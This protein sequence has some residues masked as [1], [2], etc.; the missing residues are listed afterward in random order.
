MRGDINLAFLKAP[1]PDTATQSGTFL[2]EPFSVNI[3][4]DITIKSVT[5]PSSSVGLLSG[6]ASDEEGVKQIVPT[7]ILYAS[8]SEVGPNS[9]NFSLKDVDE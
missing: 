3:S 7:Q 6:P 8:L 5:L 1:L 9:L 2:L 4:S